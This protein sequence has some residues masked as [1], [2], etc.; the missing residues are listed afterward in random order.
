MAVGAFASMSNV[1]PIRTAAQHL[2][3]VWSDGKRRVVVAKRVTLRHNGQTIV[4]TPTEIIDDAFVIEL[5]EEHGIE[6]IDLEVNG[7]PKRGKWFSAESDQGA[8]IDALAAHLGI[9]PNLLHAAIGDG[10]QHIEAAV[11]AVTD[12]ARA[13]Y[14]PEGKVVIDLLPPAKHVCTGEACESWT[15]ARSTLT[16][17]SPTDE[18]MFV[19]GWHVGFDRGL[20]AEPEFIDDGHPP[21][22]DADWKPGTGD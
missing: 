6:I 9:M 20:A 21:E 4:K 19:A 18:S 16:G 5:L 17:A 10:K 11:A 14:V 8:N 7:R 1:T 3:S 12:V 22:H 2:A 15:D 13:G